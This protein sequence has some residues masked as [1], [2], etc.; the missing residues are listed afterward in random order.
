MDRHVHPLSARHCSWWAASLVRRNKKAG[1]PI[2]RMDFWPVG[3]DPREPFPAA[4][5]ER[6]TGGLGLHCVR[7][8]TG[9]ITHDWVSAKD[10]PEV[11]AERNPLA[12]FR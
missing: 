5:P 1:G 2:V 7:S 6:L 10:L 4:R 3:R 12:R 9:S 8:V 11:M